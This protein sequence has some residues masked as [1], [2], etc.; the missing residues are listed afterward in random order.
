MLSFLYLWV[1]T[2][3]ATSLSLNQWWVTPGLP[4]WHFIMHPPGASGMH[5]TL[6]VKSI[7][8]WMDPSGLETSTGGLCQRLFNYSVMALACSAKPTRWHAQRCTS[9]PR[10]VW[11]YDGE[12]PVLGPALLKTSQDTCPIS[13]APVAPARPTV[14]FPP[15]FVWWMGCVCVLC[16]PLPFFYPIWFSP[17]MSHFLSGYP[18]FQ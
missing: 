17:I 4:L 14:V 2:R 15:G 5:W 6:I 1:L 18:C 8:N 9:P 3:F 7:G 11:K 10:D 12:P 13:A 16:I